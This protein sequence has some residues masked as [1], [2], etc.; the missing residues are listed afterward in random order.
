MIEVKHDPKIKFPEIKV[1]QYYG[2]IDDGPNIIRQVN[3]EGILVPLIRFN[4]LVITFEMV[5]SMRLTNNILPTISLEIDD[6][7]ELIRILDQPQRDNILYLQILPPF[8]NAYKKIQLSFYITQ[9]SI[10]G[11]RVSMSGIYYIPGLYDNVMKPYGILS[12]Y[13]LFEK[14]SND[15]SLGFCSNVSNIEDERYIYNPNKRID[16]FL[17]DEVQFAGGDKH[18]FTWWIDFW[19]NINLVDLYQAYNERVSEEKL[20]VWIS[21]NFKAT[22]TEETKPY[23]QVAAFSNLPAFVASPLYTPT[24]T[25]VLNTV[26]VTDK[27]FEIHKIKDDELS[28]T[29][30]QDGDVHNDIFMNYEYGGEV[31]GDFDY[32]SQRACRGM[33]L[34]KINSQCIKITSYL[35]LLGLM[36]GGYV[37]VWWYDIDSL[38]SPTTNQDDINTNIDVPQGAET[39]L[40]SSESNITLNKTVSGQYYIVNIEY[41]YTGHRNWEVNYTLSRSAEY[42]QTLNPPTN[43]TFMKK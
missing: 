4:N 32:L 13:G 17:N 23:K 35:P 34:N 6:Y 20:Q 5:S 18:V 22:D 36:K 40:N 7:L 16:E 33:L 38:I 9:T 24:Y 21:D 43:E 15:Y 42:I 14:I 39:T 30:I 10:T 3:M 28:S 41:L 19:N 31:F 2:D 27:N 37:N 29:V 8:D 26:M 11:N 25:P 12:T 1:P